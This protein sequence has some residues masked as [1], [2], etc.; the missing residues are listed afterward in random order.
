MV[1]LTYFDVDLLPST[2]FSFLWLCCE[3][4]EIHANEFPIR[5]HFLDLTSGNKA[6]VELEI[7][8]DL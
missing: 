2:K 4:T 7:G 1:A 5:Y 8:L 3:K 6:S